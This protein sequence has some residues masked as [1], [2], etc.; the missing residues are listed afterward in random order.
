MIETLFNN[1]FNKINL[2]HLNNI[3]IYSAVKFLV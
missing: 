3:K 2:L 1:N